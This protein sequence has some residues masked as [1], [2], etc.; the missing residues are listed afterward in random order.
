MT[1][2]FMRIE[3]TPSPT[4]SGVVLLEVCID[5]LAGLRAAV[6]GRPGRLEVCSRLDLD[7]LTPT[8]ELLTAAVGSGIECVAMVRPRAGGF[9]YDTGEVERMI[10]SIEH[11]RSLGARGIVLGA[12]TQEGDVDR[13]V[14][15]EWVERAAPLPVTF[16]RA[17]DVARDKSAALEVLVEIGVK[18]VLTSGGARS[19]LEGK[20]VLRALVSQSRGRIT[21]VAG[22]GVRIGNAQEIVRASGVREIHS[23]TVFAAPADG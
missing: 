19:A 6:E 16:H 23:S 10:E 13:D 11:A 8:D 14:V 17:F 3:R 21:I 12:L 15:R 20:D 1:V 22:G 5:S 7:G 2:M 18:R 9:V 4:L